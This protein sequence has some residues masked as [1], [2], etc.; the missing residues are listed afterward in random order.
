M[1]RKRSNC[2]VNGSSFMAGPFVS[3]SRT[4]CQCGIYYEIINNT[5]KEIEEIII[6]SFDS[7]IMSNDRVYHI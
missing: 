6:E 5:D 2:F 3:F 4:E 1:G 7:D